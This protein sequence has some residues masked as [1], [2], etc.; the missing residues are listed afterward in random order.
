MANNKEQEKFISD[1]KSRFPSLTFRH[2]HLISRELNKLSS[3]PDDKAIELQISISEKL[4][5]YLTF[6]KDR[7][8]HVPQ[9]TYDENLP[10]SQKREEIIEAIKSNQVVIIA[11]ETGSGK[12]TQIPKMCLEAGLGRFGFIGHTQPRRIAARAV[13][14]RIASELGEELGQSVGYKVRFNDVTSDNSYI[15]LMT[16]GILLAETAHDRKLLNYD[17]IIIDEAHERSLNIDFLLGYLKK[18]LKVRSDLKLIITSATINTKRFSEHFDNAPIIE[19]SGRTYPVEVVYRPLGESEDSDADDEVET[20]EKDLRNGILN[21][22]KF[23]FKEYG[24]ED[25]LVFLPGEREIMDIAKFLSK[26]HLPN[27]E[28]LPLYARLATSDQN[29]IFAPHSTVR[30][31]LATNVAETSLTVPG[32][33][34]VIDPGT[35]RISRYSPRTKVQSLPIEKISKASADQRKGRCGRVSEG[36]CVRLYSKEDFEL[37]QDFTDPEILRTNLASVILQMVSLRLGNITVFPFIDPPSGKQITDG[38]RLLEEVGA[39][40]ESRGL[41]TD[42]LRLTKI[43]TDL[44]KIPCDPR[45]SRML[46]EAHKEGALAEV[47]VIVS[48]MAVM[49][50]RERPVDRQEQSRQQHA[51]FDDEK[52]DFLAYLNLYHYICKCQKEM[53]NSQLRK[54]LKSEFISYLRVREWFDLLRQLRASCQMLKYKLNEEPAGYDAVHRSILSGLLSQVGHY[55][56]NDKGLYLGARGIKFVIH[57]SSVFNKKKPKWICAGELNETSRLFARTV[58]AIDPLW[59]ETIGRHLVKKNYAEPHWSK[60]KGSVVANL[61][62]SLY[63]LPVV[64]GRKVLY[65]S[66]DPKLCRELFIRD[67]LVG[68]DIEC[69]HAFFRHN[70]EVIDEVEHVEDKLRRRDLLVDSSVLEEFYDKKLPEDILTQRH[71][72]KWWQQKRKSDPEYLNFSIDLVSKDAFNEVEE[73]DFPEFWHYDSFKLPLSYIFDPTSKD[74]GVT[75]HIPL[76][77]VNRINSREFAYQIPGLRLEFLTSLI[78]SLPK[79]LRKNLIPAPNYAKALAES[80]GGPSKDDLYVKA[81]KELTR[82]G[83]E[84][85]TCDD[86]DKTLIEKHLF[87]IFSIEDEKGKVIKKGRNFDSIAASLQGQVKDVLSKYAS[88]STKVQK[89]LNEW[90]F[91]TIKTTEVTCQNGIE[92]TAYPALTDKGQ[93]VTLELYDSK[94]KQQKAMWAGQRKLLSLGLKQPTAYLEQHL[95]NK[96]KLS[97]YYQP[98]G[99]VKDLIND[100]M[101]AAIDMIMVE[102][103]APVYDEENFKRLLEKVRG[104]LNDTALKLCS[105]VEKI[106]LKAHELKRKLKGQLNLAVAYSYKDMAAQLDSLVYKG[107]LSSTKVEYLEQIPRYLDAMLYRIEK[108]HR[109]VNRDLVHTRKIEE[110]NTLYKNTLSR[111]KYTAIPDDLI[112]V[113]WLIEELRVSYFA[114]QLG[115]RVSIS[116]KRI[117]NELKRILEEY[118]EHG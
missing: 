35:A 62:I 43:G 12:T 25:I 81:A 37:R 103:G 78:K 69:N 107:F 18:L 117:A 106:L 8:T 114:Q 24:R 93:G 74:D 59:V 51:R 102:N 79:R 11:G 97:M 5:E 98:L 90:N 86:F 23:L 85:V 95:P 9:L 91:G 67:G 118:P 28:I 57:P 92:I 56:D 17:C 52:S 39:I 20:D 76:A 55:D 100:L 58:A 14:T 83:G 68:G 109:D 113:K 44:S 29:K 116:D 41:S 61:T 75:V 87:M 104:D 22:I 27:T 94:Y 80:I 65:T 15:K 19:V 47:L 2:R 115:V 49:D 71:F 26:A 66:I 54:K 60:S 7:E 112:N 6:F 70:L 99:T 64:Q 77:I 111:Y 96:S 110:V 45:L 1:V 36:V 48:A 10:V 88:K 32:I 13:S 34:Y 84:I 3:C 89:P 108:V 82:M 38:I 46:V 50:P 33:K 4:E 42:E 53:S 63:G 105:T 16:D 21:A 73:H 40:N 31:V 72:D 101:L 30:V